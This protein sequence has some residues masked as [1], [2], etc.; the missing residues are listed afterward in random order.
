MS[1]EPEKEFGDRT[2]F[3]VALKCMGKVRATYAHFTGV[4]PTALDW[5]LFDNYMKKINVSFDSVLK[6]EKKAR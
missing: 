1:K 6:L 2:E 4:S 5:E 3:E